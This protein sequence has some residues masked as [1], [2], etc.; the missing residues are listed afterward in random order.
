[1]DKEV[2]ARVYTPAALEALRSFPIDA[3]E[4]ELVSVSENVTFR[5]RDA[6]DAATY[7]LRLHRPGYHSLDELIAERVWI[8]ALGDAGIAVPPPLAATDGR[9]Y[10]NVAIDGTGERRFAGVARWTEGTVLAD[11]LRH[12]KSV[13]EAEGYFEQLGGIAAAMHNQASAWDMPADFKRHALDA[14]GLMGEAPFWGR[15]W[16]HPNLSSG[17]R[18]LLSDTRLRVRAALDRLGRDRQT[19][20]VIHADLHA[21]N[22]LVDGD[23]LTVIDFDDSGFGWH[24]YDAAVAMFHFQAR[25]GFEAIQRGFVRGYR[26]KR[27]ISDAAL[28]SDDALALIPMFLMIRG[29][30]VIGWISQRPELDTSE[31]LQW[32]REHVC[33]QCAAFEPPC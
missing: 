33:A 7:V 16:E 22:V 23:R 4:L 18:S 28:A 25:D 5:V 32:L 10:V 9:E 13:G 14:D 20:S 27:Y 8:R 19:F 24:H 31:Y 15:F 3:T 1:M 2:A 29:M 30:A 26:A 21:G 17:E 12:T 11:A 6:N